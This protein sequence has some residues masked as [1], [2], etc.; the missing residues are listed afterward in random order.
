MTIRN[1]NRRILIVGEG[2][3]TEYN[4]FV[5]LRNHHSVR[6]REM[7]TSVSVA[8]GK[9]GNASNIVQNAIKES[10]KFKP[11]RKKGDRVFLL[12][13][14]E[15]VGRAPE[16]PVAEKLA[17]QHSIEI[18]YS[19]PAFEYWLLCHFGNLPK[20]YMNDC[21]AVVRCLNKVW[22]NVS[23]EDYKKADE[24]V[25]KRLSGRL[26]TARRQSLQL[27]LEYLATDREPIKQ[28]PSSQVYE[29]VARLLGTESSNQCPLEGPWT[30]LYSTS[31]SLKLEKGQL[32]PDFDGKV[33]I[34]KPV[35]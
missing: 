29:L 21:A 20:S 32:V 30:A 14:T 35:G 34:W 9:G 12:L 1:T 19:S 2:K 8:R 18:V 33:A 3:E 16:L 7:A 5:G 4:Y 31:A 22:G 15:G 25:F 11:D 23:K 17:L 6:L 24:K 10:K 27:D 13:D 26:E 28:N